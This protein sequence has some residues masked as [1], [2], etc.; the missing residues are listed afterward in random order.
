MTKIKPKVNVTFRM[1]PA[2]LKLLNIVVRRAKVRRSAF[3]VKAVAD[4]VSYVE[5]NFARE[6]MARRGE[7]AEDGGE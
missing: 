5:D 2:D 7:R 3:I 4:R 6:R 1:D